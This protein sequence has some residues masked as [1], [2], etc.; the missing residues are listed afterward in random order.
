MGSYPWLALETNLLGAL[1]LA[2]VWALANRR[3]ILC[4]VLLGFAFLCR[5][6]AGLL[7][8]ICVIAWWLEVHIFPK[9]LLL[10]AFV[11]V[12]PWLGWA[13][14]Y[15]GSFMP[16]TFFAK[17]HITQPGVYFAVAM[18]RFATSPWGMSPEAA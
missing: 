6:D 18:S 2:V 13:Q 10:A 17:Q 11:V 8:P 1:V 5:Y 15:F 7:V 16:Q 14:I 12:A 9:R 4:G 3:E